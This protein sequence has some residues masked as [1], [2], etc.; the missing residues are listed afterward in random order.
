MNYILK[1]IAEICDDSPA[2]REAGS[3]SDF[4][5]RLDDFDE[6][7]GH[8]LALAHEHQRI[9]DGEPHAHVAGTLAGLHIDTC[10]KCGRD[11]REAVHMSIGNAS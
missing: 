8:I 5:R 2:P 7:M 10:A 11:L 1:Q 6:R 4:Q 9:L 3:L